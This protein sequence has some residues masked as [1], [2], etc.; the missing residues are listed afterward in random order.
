MNNS[1]AHNIVRVL[2][3]K[4]VA[5][6]ESLSKR[7]AELKEEMKSDPWEGTE[8]QIQRLEARYESRVKDAEAL[9]IA[10]SKF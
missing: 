4:A 1:E 7:I 9:A 5:E 8:S 6:C 10:V 3:D 2:R